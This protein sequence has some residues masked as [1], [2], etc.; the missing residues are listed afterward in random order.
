LIISAKNKAYINHNRPVA[1]ESASRCA[2]NA[3]SP[4]EVAERLTKSS[5]T[6]LDA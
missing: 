4:G 6:I 1:V 3:P 2:Q 5:G